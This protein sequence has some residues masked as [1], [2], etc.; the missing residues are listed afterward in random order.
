M[1]D[2][3]LIAQLRK[4]KTEKG[5]TLHDLSKML[6]ISVSTLERWLTTE[7]INRLYARMVREKLGLEEG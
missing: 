3:E 4:F 6:D 1:V 2:K 5:Y 7:R